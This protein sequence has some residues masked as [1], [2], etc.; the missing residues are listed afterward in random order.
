MQKM[1]EL[2]VFPFEVSVASGY[3]IWHAEDNNLNAIIEQAD[4]NM[5]ENKRKMKEAQK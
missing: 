2:H 4:A 1:Y 3:S 5:Y